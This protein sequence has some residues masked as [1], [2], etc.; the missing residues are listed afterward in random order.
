MNTNFHEYFLKALYNIDG[1]LGNL[2][3]GYSLI[4]TNM[5]RISRIFLTLCESSQIWTQMLWIR[6]TQNIIK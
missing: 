1:K 4:C 6:V 5:D 2:L 3:Q